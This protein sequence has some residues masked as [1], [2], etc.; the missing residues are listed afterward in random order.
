M[1]PKSLSELLPELCQIESLLEQGKNFLSSEVLCKINVEQHT[2]PVYAISLGSTAK[3]APCIAFVG[4]I[5]GVERIGT[6]VVIA[7]LETLIERLQWDI[8]LESILDKVRII[9]MPL[10]NPAGMARNTRSNGQGVDLMR[11][12]PVDSDERVVWLAGGHRISPRLPWYRGE[13]NKDMEI[14]SQSLCD[15]VSREMFN[16]P[17]SLVL[18]CHSGFG[19]HDRIWFP[20]AKSRLKPMQHIGEVYRLR[21]LFFETYPYQNY[22]FEPQSKHYLTH[23]D[24]WDYLYEKSLDQGCTFLPL[25][26]EMGSWRW[27]RKNPL[28]LFNLIGLYHPIKPHRVKRVLRGHHVLMDF[29]LRATLSYENWLPD[30]RSLNTDKQARALWYNG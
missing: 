17:F 24:I 6:K 1:P 29:L 27:I 16:A 13:V 22:L 28:Q 8:A 11:N 14:E 3:D 7:F 19:L 20:Y 18:D 5:H 4:G 10:L 15:F 25:T 26:L 23:G 21:E 9:F 30:C 12:A 2:V